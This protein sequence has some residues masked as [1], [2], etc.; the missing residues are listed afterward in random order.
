MDY[1]VFEVGH[2]FVNVRVFELQLLELVPCSQFAGRVHEFVLECLFELVTAKTATPTKVDSE[3]S[4]AHLESLERREG[5]EEMPLRPGV[6]S[7][8]VRLHKR[9][10]L[11]ST[12]QTST[13]F[14]LHSSKRR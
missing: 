8:A 10:Y 13:L 5:E 11:V 2:V 14:I 12:G 1:Q 9:F 3:L 4:D 7:S 6:E